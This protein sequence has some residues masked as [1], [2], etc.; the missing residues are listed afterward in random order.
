MI[1]NSFRKW[2][3]M[4]AMVCLLSEW[5]FMVLRFG[6]AVCRFWFYVLYHILCSFLCTRHPFCIK[7]YPF[8][9]SKACKKMSWKGID[10]SCSCWWASEA[11]KK[12][13]CVG[14]FDGIKLVNK[15]SVIDCVFTLIKLYSIDDAC[16][17]FS[18]QVNG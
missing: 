10:W 3:F 14:K 8:R 7:L 9:N 6:H 4:V 2:P 1:Y 16:N 13:S 15:W 11:S 18:L 17:F 12:P 5:R